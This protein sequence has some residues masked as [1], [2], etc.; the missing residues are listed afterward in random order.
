MS[1]TRTD[2]PCI[3]ALLFQDTVQ[4]KGRYKVSEQLQG[5]ALKNNAFKIF[6]KVPIKILT[7]EVHDYL[8]EKQL[9]FRRGRCTIQAVRNH[10]EDK[11]PALRERKG[12][13]Y[14]VFIDDT[15]AFDLMNRRNLTQAL[16]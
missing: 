11:D 13:L 12:K 14:A 3:E 15:K 5:T 7:E 4:R 8:P 2:S 10:A 9:A 1:P 16:N 6:T